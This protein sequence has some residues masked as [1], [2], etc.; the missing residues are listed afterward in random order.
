[1]VLVI[2]GTSKPGVFTP[3][4]SSDSDSVAP[5]L[6]DLMFGRCIA[7]WLCIICVGDD[8]SKLVVSTQP[9]LTVMPHAYRMVV[10]I[11]VLV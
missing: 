5:R 3:P 6:P 2:T 1:M 9:Q 4:K 7:I 10:W 8:A 11:A